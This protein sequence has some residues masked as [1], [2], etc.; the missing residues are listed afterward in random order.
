DRH[1]PEQLSAGVDVEFSR[2][3]LRVL[4]AGT[5]RQGRTFS[6]DAGASG[7]SHRSVYVWRGARS[8]PQPRLA[9][10]TRQRCDVLFEAGCAGRGLRQSSRVVPDFSADAAGKV[11]GTF[12][13]LNR[14]N[15]V[16]G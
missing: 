15:A 11:A 2:A 13:P 8:H 12:F 1:D 16:A 7:V 3:Q 5:G 6:S 10:W 14:E 9:A 4:A